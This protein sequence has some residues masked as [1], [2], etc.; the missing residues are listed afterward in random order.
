MRYHVLKNIIRTCDEEAVDPEA[1]L[2]MK[3]VFETVEEEG[4]GSGGIAL[5]G[6]KFWR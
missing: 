5:V 1:S 6:R 2:H 3:G 4:G